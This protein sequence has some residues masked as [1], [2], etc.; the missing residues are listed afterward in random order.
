MPL[1]CCIKNKLNIKKKA[2]NNINHIKCDFKNK[3]DLIL[4]IIIPVI[5]T[6]IFQYIPLY[7][8]QIAFKNYN[9]LAVYG[10]VN[11]WV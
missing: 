10:A 4:M 2:E 3:K 1:T 8:L 9:P 6:F 5:I 7:G 11:G